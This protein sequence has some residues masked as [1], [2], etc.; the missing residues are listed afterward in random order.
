MEIMWAVLLDQAWKLC[1]SCPPISSRPE[2][3]HRS[4]QIAKEAGKCRWLLAGR[5]KRGARE[6]PRLDRQFKVATEKEFFLSFFFPLF[7]S[8][9]C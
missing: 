2:I 1:P 9:S 7:F 6:E 5:K 3:G 8:P 4:H